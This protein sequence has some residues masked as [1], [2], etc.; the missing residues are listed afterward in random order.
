MTAAAAEF[1]TVSC[2]VQRV[3][4]LHQRGLGLPVGV[5]A[6]EP[7]PTSQRLSSRGPEGRLHLSRLHLPQAEVLGEEH[8]SRAQ[9]HHHSGAAQVAAPSADRSAAAAPHRSQLQRLHR[10]NEAYTWTNPTCCVHNI[11]VGQ[12]WIEQYGSVEVIN[13]K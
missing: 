13:H 5:G 2:G 12:L 3:F 11:I 10:Y 8:R 6:S 4:F 1:P 7:P 9:R